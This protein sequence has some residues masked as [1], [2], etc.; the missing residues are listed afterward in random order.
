MSL[1]EVTYVT[2][3]RFWLIKSQRLNVTATLPRMPGLI[4]PWYANVPA[5]ENAYEN[6]A[7]GARTSD[8][9]E[10]SSATIWC[11]VVS[12]FFQVTTSPFWT[13]TVEGLKPV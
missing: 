3:W 7:P 1:T 12:V 8:L 9:N 6:V 5:D 11:D 4:A 13:V 2:V 10:P